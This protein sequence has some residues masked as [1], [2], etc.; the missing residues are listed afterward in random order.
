M[1]W[2]AVLW[3]VITGVAAG[4]SADW[5]NFYARNYGDKWAQASEPE[6]KSEPTPTGT[7]PPQPTPPPSSSPQVNVDVPARE[8]EFAAGLPYVGGPRVAQR[9]EAGDGRRKRRNKP[10]PTPAEHLCARCKAAMEHD[11][12]TSPADLAVPMEADTDA[13]DAP[14]ALVPVPLVAD[15]AAGTEH[16]IATGEAAS[17]QSG[18]REVF[19]ASAD[20]PPRRPIEH[21]LVTHLGTRGALT[22]LVGSA[23]T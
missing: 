8:G 6:P 10:T 5:E 3:A 18:A 13:P 16:G 20:P 21:R 1:N 7:T 9:S 2:W 23:T 17:E 11:L 12:T 14:D 19:T 15:A 4:I 22:R